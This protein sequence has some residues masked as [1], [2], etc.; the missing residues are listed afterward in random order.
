[1]Q[2]TAVKKITDASIL[3]EWSFSTPVDMSEVSTDLMVD[4]LVV[5]STN[6]SSHFFQNLKPYTLYNISITACWIE[7]EEYGCGPAKYVAVETKATS[8]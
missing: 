1:M 4:G 8:K 2:E 5:D 6:K 3:L 7:Y